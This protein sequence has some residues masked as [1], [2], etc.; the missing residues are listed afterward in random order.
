MDE[1]EK[2]ARL[3]G[4]NIDFQSVYLKD[5]SINYFFS[6]FRLRLYYFWLNYSG[7][8]LYT[9]VDF[10]CAEPFLNPVHGSAYSLYLVRVSYSYLATLV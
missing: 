2:G 8:T 3:K 4:D 7:Y 10:E 5:Y 6:F 9:M 1:K